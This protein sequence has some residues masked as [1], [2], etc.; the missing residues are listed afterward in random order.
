M[1][2]SV[3]RGLAAT[4]LALGALAAATPAATAASARPEPINASFTATCPGFDAEVQASGMI[5]VI[6]LP[7]D[8]QFLTGPNLRVTVTGPGGSVSYVVTGLTMFQNLPGGGQ[9]VTA[10]GTNLITVPDANGHLAGLYYT[11][12]KVSWTLDKDGHEVGGMF[13]GSGTVTDVCAAI[14]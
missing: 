1:N 3:T 13:T 2:T 5:G 11:R 12:G 14:S 10:T 7:G 4:S 8:R 6:N 9:F